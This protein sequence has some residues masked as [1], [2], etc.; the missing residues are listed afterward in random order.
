MTKSIKTHLFEVELAGRSRVSVGLFPGKAAGE[1]VA[2]ATA[3]L[4]AVAQRTGIGNA[5]RCRLAR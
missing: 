3:G 5:R 2:A 1:R 4:K